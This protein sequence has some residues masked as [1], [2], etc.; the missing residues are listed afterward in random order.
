[1]SHG[2]F[3]HGCVGI[4]IRTSTYIFNGTVYKNAR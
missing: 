2:V 4:E 1:L 3:W